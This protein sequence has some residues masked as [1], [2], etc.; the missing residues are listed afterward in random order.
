MTISSI[1]EL[2][3]MNRGSDR[4]ATYLT[5]HSP[6]LNSSLKIIF[7]SIDI[8]DPDE[9]WH[10]AKFHLDL[11]CLS[12][13]LFTGFQYTLTL[14]ILM[15]YSNHIDTISMELS[16]LYFK[17]LSIYE[18]NVF[19]SLKIFFILATCASRAH[20]LGSVRLEIEGLLFQ[21]SP[22]V[23]SLCC[24]LRFFEQDIL[25][26]VLLNIGSTQED[27]SRWCLKLLTW[28]QRIEPPKKPTRAIPDEMPPFAAFHLGLHC[29]HKNT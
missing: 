14:F 29:L 9:I 1:C 18:N 23:E 24:V 4:I 7:T 28:T 11:R 17:G 3:L 21:A 13:C 20:W 27:L 6:I 19:L 8:L 25:S 15:D 22:Q 5:I 16:I 10:T 12:K 2:S 26:S